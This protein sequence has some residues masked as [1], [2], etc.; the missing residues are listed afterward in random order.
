MLPGPC[1]VLTTV[2][3]CQLEHATWRAAAEIQAR[4]RPI[5]ASLNSGHHFTIQSSYMSMHLAFMLVMHIQCLIEVPP[6]PLPEYRYTRSS[7]LLYRAQTVKYLPSFI[8]GV[9]LSAEHSLPLA[10]RSN[11]WETEIFSRGHAYMLLHLVRWPKFSTRLHPATGT[12]YRLRS[13]ALGCSC[14]VS[15]EKRKP[16]LRV[17]EEREWL[18]GGRIFALHCTKTDM[19]A[20]LS[21]CPFLLTLQADGISPSCQCCY[22]M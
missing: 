20:V 16:K 2:D 1:L 10:V 5:G 7:H 3:T 17:S 9:N 4:S 18:L 22:C 12:S 19:T 15:L 13:Y 8:V 14:R 21:L 11:G 6:N